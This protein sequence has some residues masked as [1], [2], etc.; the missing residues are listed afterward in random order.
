LKNDKQRA[1]YFI[2]E[3]DSL[4]AKL[5]QVQNQLAT[6]TKQRSELE[7]ELK[8]VVNKLDQERTL[9]SQKLAKLKAAL[10]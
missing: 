3:K 1:D 4:V 8:F 10:D 2:K 5:K 6:S 7:A 9:A